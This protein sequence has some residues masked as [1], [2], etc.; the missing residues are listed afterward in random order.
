MYVPRDDH[1]TGLIRLLSMALR[2]LTRLECVV[3]RSLA[4][5]ESPLA[6]LYAGNPKRA[7]A[8]PTAERLLEAFGDL[9]LTIIQTSQQLYR[10]L[11]PLNTLHQRIVNALGLSSE[12][13][14]RLCMV[15]AEPPYKWANRKDK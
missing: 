4:V 15:S 6:G 7:T 11:R 9:T 2:V 14:T 3:R 10:Y 1:A 8:R 5:Q 12:I 13:Y